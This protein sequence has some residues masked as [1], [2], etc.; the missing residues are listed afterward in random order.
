MASLHILSINIAKI[1]QHFIWKQ[2]RIFLNFMPSKY[3]GAAWKT[4][5]KRM[6]KMFWF[7]FLSTSSLYSKR[8]CVIERESVKVWESESIK[9]CSFKCT[10]FFQFYVYFDFIFVFVFIFL[11]PQWDKNNTG[12]VVCYSASKPSKQ[13]RV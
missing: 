13:F 1:K 9:P 3:K 10:V 5:F 4:H 12:I 8:K 2:H 7:S 6:Y 11:K